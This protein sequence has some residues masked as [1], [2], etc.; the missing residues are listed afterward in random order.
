MKGY[1]LAFTLA[2]CCVMAL[3]QGTPV[4]AAA[5]KL[6]VDI[7]KAVHVSTL[8][9]DEKSQISAD[10]HQLVANANLRAKGETPD[11]GAGRAAGMDIGKKLSSG[12][13]LDADA[14]LIRQDLKDLQAATQQ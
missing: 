3:A 1:L 7:A 4:V 2:A 13:F 6:Q 11:R 9:T 8:S 14:E 12:K 10:A 5:E